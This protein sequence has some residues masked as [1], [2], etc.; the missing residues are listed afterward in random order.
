M[1]TLLK[2]LVRSQAE[3][4]SVLWSPTDQKQINLIET[5]QRDFTRRISK[6]QEYDEELKM[7]RCMKSYADRLQELKLYSLQRRR[8]RLQILYLYKII[9]QVRPNPGF[10][11]QYCPRKKLHIIPKISSKK[12]WAQSLRNTSFSVTGPKLFNSVPAPL[13]EL[14]DLSKSIDKLIECSKITVDKYFSC[15]PGQPGMAN[16][17]LHHSNIQYSHIHY[18]SSL[19]FYFQTHKLDNR[20]CQNWSG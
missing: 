13:R 4:C 3:Y 18:S 10:K 11:W 12:G 16:S 20:F 2:L 19:F 1:K 15:I 14:P 17:I 5:V 8:E 9:L 7:P 6:F